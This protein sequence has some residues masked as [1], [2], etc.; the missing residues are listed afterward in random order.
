[1]Q[2][3][4][5]AT[6]PSLL[7]SDPSVLQ[8]GGVFGCHTKKFILQSIGATQSALLRAARVLYDMSG[9]HNPRP[10]TLYVMKSA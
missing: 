7:P 3:T 1:M 9:G 5:L 4:A 10:H 6:F 8:T 2:T